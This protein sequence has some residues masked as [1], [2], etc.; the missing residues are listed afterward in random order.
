MTT[1]KTLRLQ[2]NEEIELPDEVVRNYISREN[3]A[4]IYDE[5]EAPSDN[6]L[7][8]THILNIRNIGSG[9]FPEDTVDT[10]MGRRELIAR[11]LGDIPTGASLLDDSLPWD[12]LRNLFSAMLEPK[13]PHFWR[14]R[15]SKLLH[16][17]RPHLIPI[18]DNNRIVDDYCE[19]VAEKS[20]EMLPPGDRQEVEKTL[21]CMEIL[22]VD[23]DINRELLEQLS[24]ESQRTPLRVLDILLWK[25]QKMRGY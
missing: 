2:T 4:R 17:F 22:K 20:G 6:L 13:I 7:T 25:L 19:R 11:A 23:A 12:A 16:K 8:V 15:S 10:L 14:S 24:E 1:L 3:F 18:L 9:D 21:R 5:A